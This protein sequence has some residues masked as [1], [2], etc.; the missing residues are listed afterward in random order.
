MS[1]RIAHDW[2]LPP[3]LPLK[4]CCSELD[5]DSIK[6]WMIDGEPPKPGQIF[7]NPDLARTFSFCRPRRRCVLPRRDRARHR[8]QVGRPGRHHDLGGSRRLSRANGWN[9]R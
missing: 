7:K 2:L 3:A 8:R 9:R 1:E 6:A 4:G 5:P